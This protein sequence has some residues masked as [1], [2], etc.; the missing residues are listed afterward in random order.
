LLIIASM[1]MQTSI[2]RAALPFFMIAALAVM[3][4]VVTSAIIEDALGGFVVD[5]LPEPTQGL[6]GV[7]APLEPDRL[8]RL[9][10]FAP[11]QPARKTLTPPSR[12]DA[13]VLGT[14]VSKDL[15]LSLASIQLGAARPVSVWPG[16]FIEDALVLAI[17][18]ESVIVARGDGS[19]ERL[20]MGPPNQTPLSAAPAWIRESG[21]G[22][23]TLSRRA[24]I[25]HLQDFN[26][27]ARDARVVPAFVD[28]RVAGFKVLW[29]RPDSLTARLGVQAGDVIRAVNGQPLDTVQRVLELASRL[30][31]APTFEVDLDRLGTPVRRTYRLN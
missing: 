13:R 4:G 29:L 28:G 16:D 23:F 3:S 14:L 11:A 19:V 22:E 6:P 5:G 2:A 30:D 27:L 20:V 10:G 18:R 24:V 12:L 9:F 31:S 25:E 7:E 26:E 21:P 8:C 1:R 15:G 17:E